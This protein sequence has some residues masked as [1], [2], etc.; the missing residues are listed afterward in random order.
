VTR[1]EPGSRGYVK[2]LTAEHDG[3]MEIQ[4]NMLF[5]RPDIDALTIGIEIGLDLA[6]QPAFRKLIK[7]WVAP[8]ERMTSAEART[9]LRR[10]CLPYFYPVGTCA[11]GSDPDA[12]VSPGLEVHGVEGLRIAD[13]SV[14]PKIPSANTNAPSM[15]IGEFA[16]TLA[17]Q[18]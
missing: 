13:A 17:A 4:P 16:A 5:E 10:S 8:P 14:M 15:M 18:R 1:R 7:R 11:T 2:L 9:F 6:A 12:V 3:P